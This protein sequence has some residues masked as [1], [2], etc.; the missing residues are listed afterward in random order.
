[1]STSQVTPLTAED[2]VDVSIAS[3]PRDIGAVPDLLK[4]ISGL[5]DKY[6]PAADRAT[7]LPLLEKATA[8][9]QALET[10]RETMLKHVGAETASFYTLT[11]GIE[12]GLFTELA[13]NG[14]SPKKSPELSAAL[15]F[16][17]DGLRRIL[18]HFAAMGHIVQTGSDEWKPNNFSKSLTIPIVNGGYPFYR[19]V[20][21]APL[22]HMHK[23]MKTKGYPTPTTGKDNPFTFGNQT[24]QS[25]FEYMA[26]HPYLNDCFNHH[27]GGYRLGRPAWMDP[28]VY[29]V[30]DNLITN[31]DTSSSSSDPV[32][33][34]DIGGNYGHDLERFLDKWPSVPG[35]IMLQDQQ[36]VLDNVPATL[37][38]GRIE[39]FAHDF[40]TPQPVKGARAYYLHH[41][42]HDWPDDK[43]VEI[44]TNLKGAMTPG[45]SKLL[46]NEHVIPSVG[47][48]WEATYL[49]LYMMFL[50][51]ARERTEDDWKALLEGKCGLK[52]EKIWNP[53][54][55]VEGIIECIVEG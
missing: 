21:T 17:I 9:A 38:G 1:M 36:S 26:A 27:M 12:V 39:K 53:G 55:G 16:D 4:D 23:W 8:L 22:L 52:I 34:I 19:S 37:G 11:L 13:K 49:D 43:C 31:F 30:Q 33:L 54:N 41:I 5:W 14:G 40:F 25:M 15:G 48:S 47:A 44:V 29:P 50:F 20:C 18:R 32:F 42:L 24:D 6:D 46:V 28:T 45:Y 2:T 35:R 10:P 7:R 51:G 3:A